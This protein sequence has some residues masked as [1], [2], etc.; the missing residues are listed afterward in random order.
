MVD[1]DDCFLDKDTLFSSERY[2]TFMTRVCG[3]ILQR[4]G[5]NSISPDDFWDS[6]NVEVTM[7]IGEIYFSR[8]TLN[9]SSGK[10]IMQGMVG[11]L[12]RVKGGVNVKS[13]GDY[14]EGGHRLH[15]LDNKLNVEVYSLDKEVV[16]RLKGLRRDEITSKEFYSLLKAI[17]DS[18]KASEGRTSQLRCV[19]AGLSFSKDGLG[20]RRGE[21][22]LI[23]LVI[24]NGRMHYPSQNKDQD[25][26][27]E[28]FEPGD[29]PVF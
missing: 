12:S 24:L 27:T 9:G 4:T 11:P 28:F 6:D 29:E 16:M 22:D 5:D 2:R 3:Q 21:K 1:I 17:E 15:L 20:E 18:F 14:W 8:E 10:A 23:G 19:S 7:N 26:R 25:L 13:K